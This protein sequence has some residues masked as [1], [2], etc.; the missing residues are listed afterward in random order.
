MFLVKSAEQ[1]FCP[2]CGNKLKVS[3][4]RQRKYADISGTEHAIII[5]RLKCIACKKTHHELPDILVPYKHY[6]S[7]SIESVITGSSQLAV[8]VD[9]ST[10]IRWRTWFNRLKKYILACLI[11]IAIRLGEESVDG[12]SCRPESALEGIQRYTGNETGWLKN[13]VRSLANSNFW[14]HTQSAFLSP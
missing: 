7:E 5:R 4:S 11:S 2:C 9:N 10:I 3:G 14:I 12:I 1:N 13:A 8:A 6:D